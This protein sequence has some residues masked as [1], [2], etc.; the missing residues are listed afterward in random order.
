VVIEGRTIFDNVSFKLG[1]RTILGVIGPNGSGKTTLLKVLVGLLQATQGSV[2]IGDTIRIGYNAQTREELDPDNRVWEEITGGE[3]FIQITSCGQKMPARSYVAQF[4]FIGPTQQKI[5]S[6]L[7]G[8]ERNRVALAKSLT[9]GCNVIILDEPTNDLDVQTLRALEEALMDFEGAAIVVS[10]DRW[11]LDRVA[12][13]ILAFQ[14]DG[15]TTHFAGNYSEWQQ[16][17]TTKVSRSQES[18]SQRKK[19][20]KISI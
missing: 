8:G 13:E 18:N 12:T 19:F 2:K 15:S 4:N 9:Q 6:Q 20:Q 11:F 10:H 1:K 17:K 3:E 5:I 7:S 16:S 14:A